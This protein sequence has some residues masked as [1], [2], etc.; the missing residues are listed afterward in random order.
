MGKL[1]TRMSYIDSVR[2]SIRPVLDHFV[3]LSLSKEL[4]RSLSL[5]ADLAFSD[6]L[7]LEKFQMWNHEHDDET[8]LFHINRFFE[9][10]DQKPLL[11]SEQDL[12]AKRDQ[13]EAAIKDDVRAKQKQIFGQRITKLASE[14]NLLTNDDLGKFLGVSGEQARKFKAGENKPQLAT[15]KHIADCFSVAVEFLIGLA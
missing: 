1:A 2:D 3:K 9:K 12:T 10:K 6:D 5:A 15:L 4:D 8:F 11:A 13:I 7:L 14:H